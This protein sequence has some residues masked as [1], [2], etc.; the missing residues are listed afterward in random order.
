MYDPQPTVP[1]SI[2]Y[3]KGLARQLTSIMTYRPLISA[4]VFF[5]DANYRLTGSNVHEIT[6][7]LPQELNKRRNFGPY[8]P[9]DLIPEGCDQPRDGVNPQRCVR[10]LLWGT[11]EDLYDHDG[12]ARHSQRQKGFPKHTHAHVSSVMLRYMSLVSA[13]ISAWISRHNVSPKGIRGLD[14]SE[15]TVLSRMPPTSSPT[16]RMGL[17]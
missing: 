15:H 1:V 14:Q 6:R 10:S 16:N 4:E 12:L 11:E 5:D 2:R 7:V 8:I 13:L 3:L 9:R 17:S